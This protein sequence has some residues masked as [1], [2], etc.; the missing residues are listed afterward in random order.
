[1]IDL[2]PMKSVVVSPHD[3]G[4]GRAGRALG[5]VRRRRQV[6]GSRRR[7]ARSRT[8][9]RGLT[10]GGGTAAVALHGLRGQP[11]RAARHAAGEVWT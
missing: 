3:A 6:H 9:R 5:R 8:R 1:M 4:L 10:L 2:Q 7:A 11:G